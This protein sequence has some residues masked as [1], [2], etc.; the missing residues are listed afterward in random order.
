MIGRGSGKA[1]KAPRRLRACPPC[2]A[3]GADVRVNR[4]GRF[5]WGICKVV[6][7]RGESAE[8]SVL[9]KAPR[10]LRACP[11]CYAWGA[12]V[13][14]CG[15]DQFAVLEFCEVVGSRCVDPAKSLPEQPYRPPGVS[16]GAGR[17]QRPGA[18]GESAKWSVRG[19][20]NQQSGRFL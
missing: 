16:Q 19:V 13:R 2:Y 12:D 15:S 4:S 20:A 11:P 10:R 6:G 9:V 3:W 1:A 5:S 17:V 7:S 14:S 8:W 18:R